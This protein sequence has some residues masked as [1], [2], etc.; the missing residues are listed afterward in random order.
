MIYKLALT[1]TELLYLRLVIRLDIEGDIRNDL[2]SDSAAHTL[3]AKLASVD[4][5]NEG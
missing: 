3:E 5:G 4:V 2:E 1:E